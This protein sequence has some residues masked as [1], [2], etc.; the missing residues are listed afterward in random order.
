MCGAV[1]NDKEQVPMEQDG[2]LVEV[3]PE[4]LK[5]I[6]LERLR[7]VAFQRGYKP[8]WVYYRYK[9]KFGEAPPRDPWRRSQATIDTAVLTDMLRSAARSGGRVSW[10]SIDAAVQ[11]SGGA[12]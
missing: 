3:G 9:E 7:A 11:T 5:R 10:S 6:E 1:L 4:D 12:R 2:T 8:G